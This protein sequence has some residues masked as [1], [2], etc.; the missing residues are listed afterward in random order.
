MRE[1]DVFRQV[2]TLRH[3]DATCLVS[4][5]ALEVHARAVAHSSESVRP[6]FVSDA[7]LDAIA[8]PQVSTMAAIELCLDGLWRRTDGG[9]VITDVDYVAEVLAD[10][11]RP[12]AWRRLTALGRRVWTELNS[13]RFIP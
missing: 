5:P 8:A 12:H 6:S 1:R 3:R 13:D 7:D 4:G 11:A 2:E 9:Y 10:A